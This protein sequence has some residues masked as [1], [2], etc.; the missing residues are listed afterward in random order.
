R[1]RVESFYPDD[2]T[3]DLFQKV[4][5]YGYG[6][7]IAATPSPVA[8]TLVVIEF[9][10]ESAD[11]DKSSVTYPTTETRGIFTI[12][13]RY[14][15]TS[16]QT[17]RVKLRNDLFGLESD[18]FDATGFNVAAALPIAKIRASNMLAATGETITFYGDESYCPAGNKS[19]TTPNGYAWDWDYT[20]SFVADEYT[21]RPVAT[22][23]WAGSGTKTAALQVSDGTNWSAAVSMDVT[24]AAQ[25]TTNLDSALVDGY[26][27]L[28]YTDGRRAA[29]LEGPE[30]WEIASGTQMPREAKIGGLAYTDTDVDGIPDDIETLN[31]IISN[32]RQ[33]QITLDGITRTGII[34]GPLQKHKEGGYV[35]KVAW[36]CAILLQ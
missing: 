32:G 19:I 35:D 6:Y 36:S 16:S 17:A 25:F 26:D 34:N 2:F 9:G 27:A 13:H 10:H 14:P 4:M 5:F 12:Y 20:G 29:L 7:T 31:D 1:P 28:D 22:H 11:L 24:V 30:S 21:T 15:Y 33:V 18:W 23:V 8:N 3:P